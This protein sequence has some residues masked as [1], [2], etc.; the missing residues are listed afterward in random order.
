MDD[1]ASFPPPPVGISRSLGCLEINV[2]RPTVVTPL[3]TFRVGVLVVHSLH[4]KKTES[5][6]LGSST[7]SSANS[8][9]QV[10]VYC[11]ARHP[12]FSVR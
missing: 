8:H 4:S 7:E 2:Q 5:L 3:S 10:C 12:N 1:R 11:I 9:G 6:R